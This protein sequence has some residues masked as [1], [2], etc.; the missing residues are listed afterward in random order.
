[1]PIELCPNELKVSISKFKSNQLIHFLFGVPSSPLV[2]KI[3]YFINGLTL[4]RE[5]IVYL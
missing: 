5:L 3:A 4:F 1:M 2:L